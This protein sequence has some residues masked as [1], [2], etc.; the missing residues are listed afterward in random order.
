[1]A[2][3]VHGNLATKPIVEQGMHIQEPQ[4]RLKSGIKKNV[5]ERSL[6]IIMV[7]I[8]V[9]VSTI[10]ISRYAA[11]YELNIRT[12]ELEQQLKVLKKENDVMKL[13]IT[14]LSNPHT[15]LK[16]AEKIGLQ[17]IG[18]S[19]IDHIGKSDDA[20]QPANIVSNQQ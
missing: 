14:Q 8:F 16:D 12:D 17:P 6:Y 10:V 11:V 19:E 2:K 4:R 18:I 7:L 9:I 5:S 20:S 13:K 15:L 3:Y 1:M